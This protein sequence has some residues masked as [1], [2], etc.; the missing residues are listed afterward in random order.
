MINIT[1]DAIF[2]HLKKNNYNPQKQTETNQIY[3]L[4]KINESEFPLFFRIYDGD[5][6][7]QMLTFI[8]CPLNPN[9][10]GDMARLLHLFNKELDIPGFGMDETAGVIF[11]RLMIPTPEKKV[12]KNLLDAYIS[13]FGQICTTFSAPIQAVGYG[14]TTLDEIFAQIKASNR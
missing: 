12:S 14:A 2:D 10:I 9:L 13:T 8:P 3:V 5:N 1:L 4:L 6:L 11:Y 7:L